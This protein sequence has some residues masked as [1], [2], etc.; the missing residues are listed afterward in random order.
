MEKMF[1]LAVCGRTAIVAT[2]SRGFVAANACC[3]S[4]RSISLFHRMGTREVFITRGN[5]SRVTSEGECLFQEADKAAH[6]GLRMSEPN[7][8]RREFCVEGI[9]INLRSPRQAIAAIIGAARQ[10]QGFCAFTLN[11]D[12]CA[13]LRSHR[14]FQSAYGRAQFVTADG[15]PIVMLGRLAGVR[16]QPDHRRRL[17]GAALRR[18]RAS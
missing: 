3:V 1:V 9:S 10:T 2:Q 4:R 11:L 17:G 14:A 13:K 15:F 5:W 12:H 6:G 7:A 8:H 18:G 16:L